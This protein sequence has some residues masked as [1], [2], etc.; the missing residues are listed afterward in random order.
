[1]NKKTRRSFLKQNTALAIGVVSGLVSDVVIA[2][3]ESALNLSEFADACR[4]CEK[5]RE[6]DISISANEL[7]P[8]LE[9]FLHEMVQR[10]RLAAKAEPAEFLLDI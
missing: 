4:L 2:R 5:L 6:G 3:D 1:M 7:D 10:I 9:K 8:E